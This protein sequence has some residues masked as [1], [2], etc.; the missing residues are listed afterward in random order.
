MNDAPSSPDPLKPSAPSGRLSR[1]RI[2]MLTL[3]VVAGLSISLVTLFFLVIAP[4]FQ[5]AVD[6][7]LGGLKINEDGGNTVAGPRG[8]ITDALFTEPETPPEHPLDP[9]LAV[10]A[11]GLKKMQA[12]VQDYT[13]LLVK[14]ERVNGK[15]LEEEF[16]R[17]KVR[18]ARPDET[19]AVPKSFYLRFEKPGSKIGQEVI[20]VDGENEGKLIAHPPG[21]QNLMT[22]RLD[23]DGWL[24]MQGN[25]YPITEL[26][27]ETLVMRM[28]EKGAHDRAHDECEV[29]VQRGIEVDGRPCTRVTITHPEEREHFEFHQARIYIDD[30]LD[31][32]IGY[33][34]YLWP[35]QP[36]GEPVLL[37]RYFY[38]DLK[39]N[40]GLTDL[41]FDPENPAYK[42]P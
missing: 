2:V 4:L 29:D 38:R 6:P 15:L 7:D 35:E 24:A 37:E 19:P 39:T 30:E 11:E 27:M 12:E 18:H 21:L 34:G 13:A 25:R 10:A 1:T 41:D 23:P 20:W 28:L 16:M 42:F 3:L 36:G 31:L 5:P 17:T 33:E 8:G 26:G 40:V 22:L 14:Q 9:V 32:P